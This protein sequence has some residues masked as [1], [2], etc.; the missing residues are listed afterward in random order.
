MRSDWEEAPGFK[1]ESDPVC[2]RE[3]GGCL[4]R[5]CLKFL[6]FDPLMEI[7]YEER[8]SSWKKSI[9]CEISQTIQSPLSHQA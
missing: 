1:Y 4:P 6:S 5:N 8:K 9:T 2:R 7:D 3:A